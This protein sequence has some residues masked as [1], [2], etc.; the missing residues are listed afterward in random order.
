MFENVENNDFVSLKISKTRLYQNEIVG[1]HFQLKIFGQITKLKLLQRKV[2]R[3]SSASE[4]N[5]VEFQQLI[6]LK[7]L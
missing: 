6:K 3:K 1:F 7:T 5:L 4:P 2:S